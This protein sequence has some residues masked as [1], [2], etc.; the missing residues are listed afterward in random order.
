M[1]SVVEPKTRNSFN[2]FQPHFVHFEHRASDKQRGEDRIVLHLKYFLSNDIAI[3]AN[4]YI[5]QKPQSR[6]N[7]L[8]TPHSPTLIELCCVSADV[9]MR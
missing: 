7:L 4:I 3:N 5:V 8:Q 9:L 1:D 6:A 2:H